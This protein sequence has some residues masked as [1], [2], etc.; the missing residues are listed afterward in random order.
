MA[1]ARNKGCFAISGPFAV[2]QVIPVLLQILP[3]LS[4]LYYCHTPLSCANRATLY[5][6]YLWHFC[7]LPVNLPAPLP[8]CIS[9]I[10]PLLPH[11]VP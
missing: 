4:L 6:Y 5:V 2:S 10:S 3:E 11:C 7:M 8:L 9:S 1:R